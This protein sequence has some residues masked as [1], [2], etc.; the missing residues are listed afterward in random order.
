M[1][2]LAVLLIPVAVLAVLGTAVIAWRMVRTTGLEDVE[3]VFV[4]RVEQERR[5]S[6]TSR[7][8][9]VLGIRFERT[10]L[11]LSGQ[12][13]LA[14]LEQLL[15]QAGRPDGL[16]ART[17]IRRQ[18]GM[19]A[20]GVIAGT[21]FLLGGQPVL[22][23]IT[24]LG[25]TLWM[26][27]WVRSAARKRQQAIAR[28]MPD[29]LDV[30]AVTVS[31]GLSLRAS[32]QRV[33]AAGSSP[34]AQEIRRVLDDMQLGMSRREALEHLRERND[35]PAVESW[36]GAMLQAEELGAPLGDTLQEIAQ[37][38]RRARAGEVRKQAAKAAPK[39]SLVV[40]MLIVPGALLLIIASLFL[41]QL[42][43]LTTVFSG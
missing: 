15:D 25:M 42:D 9:D 26:D 41:S 14:R 17:Y 11:Q 43:T 4:E 31:A 16:S 18:A 29:F 8:I 21:F 1:G 3:A 12:R 30:L 33:S 2:D 37:E 5:P 35:A 36:V 13:R 39:I 28:E 22:A 34:L 24:V 38:V 20:L 19:A 32:L 40:T 6:L 27:I 7:L 10:L 23:G